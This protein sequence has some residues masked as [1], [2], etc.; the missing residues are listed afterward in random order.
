MH[1]SSK[2]K[3]IGKEMFMSMGYSIALLPIIVDFPQKK[4]KKNCK[5]MF[6]SIGYSFFFFW[7]D[8]NG[9][10]CIALL[11]IIMDFYRFLG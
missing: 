6:L 5:E 2:K 4:K 9:I 8:V 11:P 1:F 10:F 3:K 7:R